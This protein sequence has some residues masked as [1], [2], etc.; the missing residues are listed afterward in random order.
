MKQE[1][2]SVEEYY[3]SIESR[4]GYRFILGNARHCGLW[5][6]GTLWPFPISTAQAAMREKLY[7]RLRLSS[8]CRVLDAGAGSGRV[9][10]FMAERGLHVQAI[11]IIPAHVEQ[12]KKFVEAR[13]VKD[14]VSVQV[15]DYHNLKGLESSS[16]DGIYTME[17]LVH[18]DD[19]EK[20]LREFRRLL[21]PN[22]VLVIHEAD[23]HTD[24]VVLADIRRLAHCQ[25]TPAEGGYETL[26]AEAGFHDVE[27]HDL[28][29]MVLPLWRFFGILG[30]IPYAFMRLLGVQHHFVNTMAGVEAYRHWGNG[31][32]VSIRAVK[33]A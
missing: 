33:R 18:A 2:P 17:T 30:A 5:K 7:A 27:V 8:G 9:A 13:N 1:C 21:R 32:Y 24:A 12:A 25:R 22:G 4:I 23:F 29:T 16:F 10:A 3:R 26:L 19:P 15:G 28:T 11:D 31:R 20:A 6:D 14:K